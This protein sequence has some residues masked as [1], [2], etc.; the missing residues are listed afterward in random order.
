MGS[1]PARFLI[2]SFLVTLDTI[3]T[4]KVHPIVSTDELN[5]MIRFPIAAF[6]AMN[7]GVLHGH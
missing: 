3:P 6:A 5:D 4:E 1:P 7:L 2:E